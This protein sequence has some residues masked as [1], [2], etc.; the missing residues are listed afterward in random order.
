MRKPSP[1]YERALAIQKEALGPGARCPYG[2]EPG[3]G[4]SPIVAFFGPGRRSP[5]GR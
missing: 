2:D 3:N 4:R 5:C 1:P